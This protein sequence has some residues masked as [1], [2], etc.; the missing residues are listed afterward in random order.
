MK[1]IEYSVKY[2]NEVILECYVSIIMFEIK[3][4]KENSVVYIHF[5]HY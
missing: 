1:D 4:E 5:V 2:L 3:G